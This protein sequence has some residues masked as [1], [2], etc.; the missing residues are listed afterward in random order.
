[1]RTCNSQPAQASTP[2]GT[3]AAGGDRFAR[4]LERLFL[5]EPELIPALVDEGGERRR[6]RKVLRAAQRTT[7]THPQNLALR[8]HVAEACS[9]AGRVHAALSQLRGILHDHP[10]DRRASILLGKLALR[11]GLYEES[12]HALRTAIAAGACYPDVFAAL[13]AA[14][15]R[16]HRCGGARVESA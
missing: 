16:L 6:T 4:R 10:H 5:A 7:L 11:E 15:A 8:Y 1:M 14:L 2:T 13:A 3:L 12:V 9:R